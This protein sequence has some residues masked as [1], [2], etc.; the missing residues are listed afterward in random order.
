MANAKKTRSRGATPNK[1]VIPVRQRMKQ[2]LA[3]KR[4]Q[5]RTALQV[6][7]AGTLLVGGA[8][9]IW[10][11]KAAAGEFAQRFPI[12]RIAILGNLKHVE[13]HKLDAAL[14]PFMRENYFS[15]DLPGV[16]EKTRSSA[17]VDD[18]HVRKEWP[19]T[20]I[21]TLQERIPVAN[22][23]KN[24]FL[25]KKGEIFFAEHVQPNPNLPT[26][27]GMADQATLIAQHYVQM[28]EVL[29]D[30]GLTIKVLEM[31]DRVSMT[32]QLSG[33]LTLVVDE[34]ESL[35]KLR[36][37]TAVYGLFPE[38]QRQ[39]FLRVDLRYENGL[40]IKWKKGNGDSNAA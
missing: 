8:T 12:Q 24:Q 35:E 37:F 13:R 20:L 18:V 5:I 32:L 19:N 40:A 39:Q 26:F 36:R 16:K 38:E 33:D 10:H 3:R 29:K 30:A 17:W 28:Q 4:A 7:A 31:T 1:P 2:T 34:K 9:G 15:V 14:Q 11:A 25:S 21:I 6:L 23:G 22:W 27:I